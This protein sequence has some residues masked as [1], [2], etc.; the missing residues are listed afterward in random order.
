MGTNPNHDLN[1]IADLEELAAEKEGTRQ[2][3][4]QCIECLEY[5]S[6]EGVC[7]DGCDQ[8]PDSD[9]YEGMDLGEILQA[10][11][12]YFDMMRWVGETRWSEWAYYL[13]TEGNPNPQV[14]VYKIDEIGSVNVVNNLE[15]S[16]W[17]WA[18]SLLAASFEAE[19][20]GNRP[21]IS[22]DEIEY[23]AEFGRGSVA[24]SLFENLD[25]EEEFSE[26]DSLNHKEIIT[27][28]GIKLGLVD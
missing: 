5:C 22:H 12:R 23:L 1:N 21:I 6:V 17:S 9:P 19:R 15:K 16:I 14:K 3:P 27:E 24:E 2:N 18:P 11:D 7:M 20:F 10:D 28:A 26:L 4:I 8:E 25:L 13:I